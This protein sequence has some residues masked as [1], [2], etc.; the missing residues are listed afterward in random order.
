VTPLY[1]ATT[2][3]AGPEDAEAFGPFTSAALADKFVAEHEEFA[4]RPAYPLMVIELWPVRE[5]LRQVREAKAEEE[6]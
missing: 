3:E 1:I 4:V 6:Y 2:I 5:G